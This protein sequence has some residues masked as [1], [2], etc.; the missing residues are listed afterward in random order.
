LTEAGSSSSRSNSSAIERNVATTKR[1]GESVGW[2]GL[3]RRQLGAAAIGALALVAGIGV[4]AASAFPPDQVA[5]GEEVWN[6]IC[7]ECHGPDSTNVDAPLLLRPDSLRRFPNAAAAHKYISESMPNE[8][9]GSLSQEEYWDVIAFLLARNGISG[10]ETP[11]GPETAASVP[12]RGQTG[13][14]G[15]GAGAPAPGG[16]PAPKP[17]GEGA[18]AP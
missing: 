7:V 17:E 11:L 2:S 14:R 18:P 3:G 9:P 12:T 10:G 15:P 6:R 4:P 8:T 1:G 5:R 16:D 13:S